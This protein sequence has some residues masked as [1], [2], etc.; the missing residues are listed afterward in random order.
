MLVMAIIVMVTHRYNKI[1]TYM[2]V[3]T[4]RQR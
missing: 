4:A 1:K 3:R 2:I